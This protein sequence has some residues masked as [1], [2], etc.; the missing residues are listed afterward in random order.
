VM[1]W[2]LTHVV[3]VSA[4]FGVGTLLIFLGAGSIALAASSYY[5]VELPAINVARRLTSR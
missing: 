5:A 3:N 1:A 2:V 4:P